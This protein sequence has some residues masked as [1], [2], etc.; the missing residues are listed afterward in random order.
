MVVDN[1]RNNVLHIDSSNDLDKASLWHCRLG[2]VKKK[3]I[4][5]LQ[6]S[7]VLESFDLRLDDTCESCLIGIMTKS[8]FTGTCGGR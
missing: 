3:C 5:Q 1:S 4:G 8:P 2:H 7:G 6:K